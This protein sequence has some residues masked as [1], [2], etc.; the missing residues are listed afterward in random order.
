MKSSSWQWRIKELFC[1][2]Q[3]TTKVTTLDDIVIIWQTHQKK[4]VRKGQT[5]KNPSNNRNGYLHKMVCTTPL[6]SHL[7]CNGKT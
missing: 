1:R 2:Q 6:A 5:T 7:D 4:R 3:W